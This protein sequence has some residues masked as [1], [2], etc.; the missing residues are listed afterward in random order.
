LF[1][2]ITH[3]NL[4]INILFGIFITLLLVIL[5]FFGLGYITNHGNYQTVPT[6]TGKNIDAAKLLLES[7]GFTVEV[8][9]SIFDISQP[10]L[11]V[12]KQSPE[13]DAVVKKGRTIYLTV[14]KLLAPTIDM[15]NLIGLSLK[16][17]QLYLDGLGLK[18]GDTTFKPDIAKN[19]ILSQLYNGVEVKQGTKI[20]VGSYISFVVGSGVGDEEVDV[21]NLIGLTYADAKSLLGN[22]NLN[23]GLPILLD[24][25]ITD[26]LKAFI[27]R[28]EPAVFIEPIPGQKINNKIKA[29]QIIDLWLS[30]TPPVKDSTLINNATEPTTP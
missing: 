3:R 22:M 19:S 21:P 4:L 29:G 5:F 26:T 23:I 27:A 30:F 14:N 24:A 13:A 2:F 16:S 17:A 7:K 11:N 25:T 1:K 18:I 8:S 6:V 15:P 20:P 12:L 9:D 10:K 28:Q